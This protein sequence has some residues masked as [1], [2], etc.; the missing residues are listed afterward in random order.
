M[1]GIH[2]IGCKVITKVVVGRVWGRLFRGVRVFNYGCIVS[3]PKVPTVEDTNHGDF[4]IKIQCGSKLLS[5]GY[6]QRNEEI[7][8]LQEILEK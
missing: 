5:E 6:K 4:S 2:V 7:D 1:L 8:R 3:K